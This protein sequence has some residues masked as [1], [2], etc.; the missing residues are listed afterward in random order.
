MQ[1]STTASTPITERNSTI[2][3]A[4][5]LSQKTWLVTLH[6]PD[7]DKISRH[8][9]EGGDHA[10]LLG[11]INRVRDRAARALGAVPAVASCYEAGYDGFWLHR[12]LMAA[13]ITNYVIDPSSI[14][15]EQRARRVKTDRIDGEKILRTLM[16]Y[17]R[18][19]PRVARMVRVPTPEQEDARR[20][21]RERH[22][23]VKEQ[24]AHTNRIKGLLRLHGFAVGN[25]RRRDWL[26]GLAQQRD[27]QGQAV[28]P[29]ILTEIENEHARL[30]LV[31]KQLDAIERAPAAADPTPAAAEMTRRSEQLLRLK[32][33]GPAFS[34]TLT[35]EVFYKDFSNRREVGSYFG[36]APSPWQSGGTDR[37][38]GIS[39]AGNPRA[40]CAAVELSWLWLRH[41]PDCELSQWFRQR[42]L[43]A[44]KRTKRI[45]IVALARKLMVALWRYLTTG[46]VPAG[47]LLKPAEA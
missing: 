41:Q 29:R 12:L 40:R 10:G 1:A 44:S 38:Q 2:F 17:L 33:L 5:E 9:L 25:P 27:C 20:A 32:S 35:Q 23:L 14:A 21:T 30:M 4:I 46:L 24:T 11:L 22:R 28:P 3:V 26:T 36:L 39:K 7:K 19:E 43:N 42:T 6:S 13:G 45:A 37:D 47:A 15:V 16:A 18:G 31:R 8:K 34:T